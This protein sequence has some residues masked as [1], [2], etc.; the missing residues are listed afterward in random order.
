VTYTPPFFDV[1]DR[2]ALDAV[3]VACADLVAEH[4]PDLVVLGLGFP[5]QQHIALGTIDILAEHGIAPPLF[6][7]VGGSLNMHLGLSRRAPTWVQRLGV[8]WMFRFLQEPRRLFRRY[9]VTDVR[10]L[11]MMIKEVRNARFPRSGR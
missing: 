8:E 11:P 10:F 3:V 4:R 9:F 2:P 6:L 1:T 5:K 7:L